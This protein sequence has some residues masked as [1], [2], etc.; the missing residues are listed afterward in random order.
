MSSLVLLHGLIGHLNI[1]ELRGALSGINV[2]TPDLIGY[3]EHRQQDVAALTLNDQAQH[4]I[5][6]IEGSFHEP[7]HL[8]GHSVGGAV[9]ALV[10][11]VRPDLLKSYLSVEG[12]FTLK[13]AFWSA[14][15]AEKPQ[16]EVEE[17]IDKYRAEPQ[18][19][20]NGA[21]DTPTDLSARLAVEWLDN[22]PA[23]AIRAQAR[24]VVAAT[25]KADY[26][27]N[28]RQ[29]MESDLPV[30]LI[31]GANSAASWDT[32]DW[33]NQL[34]RMR[35]NIR[36]TGHLMMAENPQAFAAAI[37]QAINA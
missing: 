8:L 5:Q 19:W 36:G 15:I 14:Q 17:I 35:I 1:P 26:L 27:S 37:Y 20:I 9:A 6:H 18:A 22:Q 21:I 11:C 32:P 29:T 34:C 23:T 30:Y 4:V 10:A 28:L 3:G 12:N 33:A 24:A 2:T 13:D 7:V 16:I 25:G 31:S